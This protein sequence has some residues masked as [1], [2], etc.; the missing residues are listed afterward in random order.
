MNIS[1][2][3]FLAAGTLSFLTITGVQAGYEH[4]KLEET[5]KIKGDLTY[6]GQEII[7]GIKDYS[8]GARPDFYA[9][10]E[11]VKLEETRKIKGD[12]TYDGQ[13]IVP[14]IQGHSSGARADSYSVNTRTH[15]QE[16]L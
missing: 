11:S 5:R 6:G 12:L 14:G 4:V 7:P 9:R 15:T 8:I 10:D 3:A 1:Y 2:R 16:G 13:V